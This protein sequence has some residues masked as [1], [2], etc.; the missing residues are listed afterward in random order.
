[1]RAAAEA[2]L[3]HAL[4]VLAPAAAAAELTH[5]LLV[6]Q[7][8]LEMQNEDLRDARDALEKS[9]QRFADFYEF[10]PIAFLTLTDRGLVDE[11]N[12]TATDLLG[13]APGALLRHP[14]ARYV[15]PEDADRWHLCFVRVLAQVDKADCELTLRRVDGSHVQVRIDGLATRKDG[16]P[17][18]VRMT[19]ID[20]GER[21]RAEAATV[22]S[23]IFKT[24]IL[25]AV[26]AQI[27]VLDH[28]GLIVAVNS[29]WRNFALENAAGPGEP[30]KFTQ[31]GVD[32][33]GVCQSVIGE[34]AEDAHSAHD[35]I[36]AVL[37]GSLPNF[38]LEY[39]CHSP[40]EQRWFTMNVT[41]LGDGVVISHTDITQRKLA[42]EDLRIAAVAYCGPRF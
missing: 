37:D 7:I 9:L 34:S 1:M 32:Y 8:E 11:A 18:T 41:P 33:L 13:M 15:I 30:A 6:H 28:G 35:G 25:D 42:E 31:V 21:K 2:R 40:S 29:A 19:L 23:E 17:S 10:A 36:R 16:A 4:P 27:A 14:F 3:A 20:I 39:P 22:K 24:A 26:S 38:S 12:V 5:E